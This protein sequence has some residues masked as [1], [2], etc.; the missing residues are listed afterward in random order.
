MSQSLDWAKQNKG[1][2]L[3]VGACAVG[4]LAVGY[5]L[6]GRRGRKEQEAPQA[7]AAADTAQEET[8]QA[9]T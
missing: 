4:A 5:A 1:I 6:S 2:A 7:A 9:A 8:K 3:A